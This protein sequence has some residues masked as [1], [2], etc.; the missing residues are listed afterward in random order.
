[1]KV[2]ISWSGQKSMQIGKILYDWLPVV[3]QNIKPYMSAEIDKGTRWASSV[4][5]E[6]ES[7]N[8]GLLCMTPEN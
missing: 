7:C 8:F 5:D 4:A 6:L 2:F 1:M 3:H